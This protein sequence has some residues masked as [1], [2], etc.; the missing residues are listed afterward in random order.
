MKL[1]NES[2]I[3]FN[4]LRNNRLELND[5]QVNLKE[6]IKDKINMLKDYID[7]NQI[8]IDVFDKQIPDLVMCDKKHIDIVMYHILCNSIFYNNFELEEKKVKIDVKHYEQ[9][10]DQFD[11]LEFTIY[12]NGTHQHKE[13]IKEI[14][15]CSDITSVKER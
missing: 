4:K 1:K 10:N 13:Q 12:D 3:A 11:T 6:C 7:Q 5:T 14:L 15:S 8:K 9:I 2:L